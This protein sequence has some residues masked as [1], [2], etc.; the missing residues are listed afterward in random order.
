LKRFKPLILS[1]FIIIIDQLS[2]NWVVNRIPENTVGYSLFGGFLDIIHVTNNAVAFSLGQGLSENI[3]AVLFILIPI[4]VMAYVV[5]II[6]SKKKPFEI[7]NFQ[8]WVLAGFLGGGCGNLFDRIFRQFKVVDFM[9]N[10]VYG[11]FGLERWPT[12]NFADATVVVCGI[13]MVLSIILEERKHKKET[14]NE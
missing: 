8:I 2:K 9:S 10:R 12:W 6:V 7:N 13:L 5:K 4:V 11:L 3:R 14:I 1:A